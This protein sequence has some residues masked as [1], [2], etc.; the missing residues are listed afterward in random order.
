MSVRNN[1]HQASVGAQKAADSGKTVGFIL[2]MDKPRVMFK[3]NTYQCAF[4]D[5]FMTM[6]VGPRDLLLGKNW[7]VD[8][9][10]Y[11]TPDLPEL[12]I[13]QAHLVMNFFKKNPALR[14]LIETAYLGKWQHQEEYY[15]ICKALC[16]PYWNRDAFQT[17]K[18]I[19]PTLPEHDNW[20]LKTH[21]IESKKNW[22]AGLNEIDRLVDKKWLNNGSIRNGI[23]G[24]WSKFYTLSKT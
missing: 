1:I 14:Y 18:I 6:S 19:N 4:L 8:E 13:K 20:Y 21:S 3:D 24:S 23:E 15:E 7:C 22:I 9:L 5:L 17:D 11:W 10:F 16:Y 2:G 12:V